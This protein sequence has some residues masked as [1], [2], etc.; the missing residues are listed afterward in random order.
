MSLIKVGSDKVAYRPLFDRFNAQAVCVESAYLL[1]RD[2]YVDSINQSLSNLLNTRCHVSE[3]DYDLLNPETLDY[4]VPVLFGL[5]DFSY[6]DPMNR[7][8]WQKLQRYIK[9]SVRLFEPRFELETLEVQ[10][11]NINT[12]TLT[13]LF[14]GW[15]HH[16][17]KRELIAYSVGIDSPNRS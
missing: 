10:D 5:P 9:N 17:D 1:S 12:Q 6:Y 4:G 8:S 2:E 14:T 11:F 16:N 3:A 7:L 15:I 13:C